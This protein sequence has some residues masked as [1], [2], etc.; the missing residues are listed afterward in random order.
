[1]TDFLYDPKR[2]AE[3][4]N[5]SVD[6]GFGQKS[7]LHVH[8]FD[9]LPLMIRQFFIQNNIMNHSEAAFLY[10]VKEL[11]E[12]AKEEHQLMAQTL[13]NMPNFRGSKWKNAGERIYKQSM[14]AKEMK[15]VKHQ[16][17]RIQTAKNLMSSGAGN[18]KI[19][20]NSV[21]IASNLSSRASVSDMSAS[22]SVL[23]GDTNGRP[24][25]IKKGSQEV[26]KSDLVK[27]FRIG[28]DN[29]KYEKKRK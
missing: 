27:T 20:K 7:K 25:I 5:I 6:I 16:M 3:L 22:Q 21:K 17:I 24:R 19:N 14:Q 4:L 2:G 1:M 8:E 29:E 10:K 28:R 15:L 26:K 18:P 9:D 23:V 12:E 13:A 11:L